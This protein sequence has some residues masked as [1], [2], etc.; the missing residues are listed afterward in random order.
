MSSEADSRTRMLRT[1]ARLLQRQ[2]YHA[3]GLRQIL[4][5]SGAPRGSLY[6]HFPGGKEQLAVEAVQAA[7]AR[8]ARLIGQLLSAYA[9]PADAVD[10]FVRGFAEVLRAS[11]YAEGC[12]VATISLEAAAR[13]KAIA[14]ACDQAYVQW[15]GQIRDHLIAAGVRADRAAELATLALAAA[16]GGLILSRARRDVEPLS[17]IAGQLRAILRDAAPKSRARRR[18]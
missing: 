11:E 15:E 13:S 2:G 3:T 4:A 12:P 14:A 16:E 10:A 17:V 5:E 1:A 6:F 9:D 8:V 18:R 7:S